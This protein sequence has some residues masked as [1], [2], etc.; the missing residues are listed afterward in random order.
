[1]VMRLRPVHF[2]RTRTPVGP[3]RSRDNGD[4]LSA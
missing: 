3:L 1:M 2:A 4:L